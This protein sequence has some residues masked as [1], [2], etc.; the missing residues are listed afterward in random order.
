MLLRGP[1]GTS[2]DGGKERYVIYAAIGT[3]CILGA[4]TFLELGSKEITW[5]EFINMYCSEKKTPL[6]VFKLI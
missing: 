5:K 3:A 6:S 2:G 1:S 4:L